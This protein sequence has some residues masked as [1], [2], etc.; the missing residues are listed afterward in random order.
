MQRRQSLPRQWLIVPGPPGPDA[1]RALSSLQRDSGV[2]L[3]EKW[4]GRDMRR[5]HR[6]AWGKALTVAIEPR[7][8]AARVHNARE[9]RRALLRRTPNILLSP[10]FKT[11]SHPDWTPL[12]RMRAAA[13]ARLARRKLVALGGMDSRKFRRLQPLGFQAWAGISAWAPGSSRE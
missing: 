6:L 7:G 1:W 10:L 3:L 8:D 4:P 13:L 12:P 5:L 11:A 2:L 9:L